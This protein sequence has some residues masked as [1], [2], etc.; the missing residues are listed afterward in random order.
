MTYAMSGLPAEPFAHLFA[1]NDDALAQIGALRVVAD[2]DRGFPCRV[3]LADAKAGERL[4]LFNYVSHDVAGPFRTA[5]AIYVSEAAE[6]PASFVDEVPANLVDR[7]LSL[8]AFGADGLIVTAA[9]AAPGEADTVIR[10]LFAD[11]RVAYIM[12]HFAAHGCF[13]AKIERHP[14]AWGD[15]A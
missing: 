13:A 12:A 6:A 4:I 8:R 15:N 7:S 11:T 10:L 14:G 1:M 2:A 9:L 5:Y 3:K